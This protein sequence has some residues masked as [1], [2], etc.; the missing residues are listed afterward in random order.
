MNEKTLFI[1]IN[2]GWEA[3]N[4]LRT[5]TFKILKENLGKIIILLTKPTED[6]FIEEFE[7]DNVIIKGVDFKENPIENRLR[8][9]RENF[10]SK[11]ILNNTLNSKNEELRQKYPLLKKITIPLN[12]IYNFHPVI[13][14]WWLAFYDFIFPKKEIKNL[15]NEYKPSCV[16]GSTFG[17]AKVDAKIYRYA[18]KKKTRTISIILSW[19]NITSKSQRIA[20]K[21]DKIIAWGEIMKKEAIKYLGYSTNDV[22]VEGVAHFDIYGSNNDIK[23]KEMFFE[24]NK[25]DLNKKLLIYGTVSPNLFG[26]NKET[27]EIIKN[28]IEKDSFIYPCQLLV[29]IHPQAVTGKYS[30][31]INGMLQYQSDSVMFDFPKIITGKIPFDL[32]KN[33]MVHLKEI[34]YYSD[35]TINPNSTLSIDAA[36]LDKPII[37][38]GFDGYTEVPLHKSVRRVHN[39]THYKNI[40][41]TGGVRIADTIDDFVKITNDY[42]GKSNLDSENRKRI[43]EEQCYKTD[44]MSSKRIANRI[45]EIMKV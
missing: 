8:W 30:D 33:D 42:L 45:L 9:F 28:L 36:I 15:F 40:V 3:R 24:E 21:P 26:Y 39:Y 18:K 10:L 20:A 25:L 12:Y 14:K 23:S 31:D 32:P 44:G 4:I 43:V 29:R 38:I 7:K 34:I 11:P 6:Y 27:I 5:D 41:N 35:V 22:F 2:N 17:F 37:N 19:D 13:D 16:I 1:I